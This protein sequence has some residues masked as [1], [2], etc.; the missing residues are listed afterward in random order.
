MSTVRIQVR[1]GT[2]SEWTSANPTLAAGEMG[3]ETDTR[4]IKVGTGS[5]AWTSLSYIASD[6]PGITE[7]AQ[8]AI[9]TALSMGSGLTKSYN[10]GTNTISLGIDSTVVALKSYVDDQITG[11]DNASA[12]DYV[13]LADVGNAGGPAKLDVDGNLLVPKSS[14]V[15][16]GAT[17]NDFETTLTVVDPTADRTITLPNAT[18]TVV[19]KDSTDTL[20]NKSISLTTNTITGTQAEFNSAM[21]DADFA[22]LA[23]SETLT[24]KTISLTSNTLSG[25]TAE[26]NTA[27]SDDNFV[28][29]T[30]T[31]T[32]TNK[33]LTSPTLTTPALGTPSSGTLTNATGLPVSGI[34]DS[35]SEALGL[36]SIE[37]GHASDTT[38]ARSGAGVV[39]IEG[40]EVTTNTA[41]QTL[42]NKTLTA[43]VISSITNGAATLTLPSTTGTVALTSDVTSAVNNLVDAAPGALDTLNELAAAIGDDANYAAG[44]TTALGGKLSL[45]GGTMTGA[46]T[47]SAAPASNLQ[48][49]TKLYVD[50]IAAAIAL[51][52]LNHLNDTTAVHGITNTADLAYVADIGTHNSD[53]TSV[54]GIPD[55]AALA[56]KTY[57]DGAVETHSNDTTNIHGISNF[58]NLMDK[59][60]DTMTGLLTLSGAPSSDLNA[61]TKK[62]VDDTVSGHAAVTTNVHGI[63]NTSL[64]ATTANVE[65]AKSEAIAAVTVTSLSLQNVNNTSDANK[66]VSTATQT[67]L[68]LKAPLA[69]PALT[70]T[71]TAPTA[72][73]ATDTTQ[74]ATT[75]FVRAEVAALVNSAG[76]TLD[77]LGEIATALGNDA[78]LSTTLTTSIGLK[79]PLASPTFTGTVTVAASG[80]AF[81]D[82]TQTKEGVPS[83]TP[84]IYK[85]A[86]YTLSAASERDSLIEVDSTSPVTI[87]IPTNS[88]VAYPVGTTLDILGTNT[89]LITIAGDSGVTVNATP[90]L[91]LRT[92]W[93]SC[94]L[95]KR[96]ENS[97]VAYGDLKA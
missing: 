26:F 47:L 41:T 14:I 35:T 43:P 77:T 29:L 94:T 22:S 88:A 46:I 71:P 58:A 40:V 34:V 83:R 65:T 8:D 3:V 80:V 82:G 81:T 85:T 16:E 39:T 73:A 55:T 60:G 36:G 4:K 9:D 61:A 20:T 86:S 75:A 64:L 49:A 21:S 38:I 33:T 19:L 90:G 78:N 12:A 52:G 69:S 37:L 1:R 32:L 27:L 28:T 18:G 87:T 13:L 30:G 15:L 66:P 48:P 42:T 70:G 92:Q 24:N 7:I 79:A 17:A 59:T 62:Y 6:A 31:E 93:S 96:A 89:G 45:S 10:D 76:S 97:W 74:I 50:D 72:A 44:V 95:F 63:A 84:I 67:A 91:K 68:D 56:T 11:L 25:T 54:H 53:T 51:D 2:A 23:G 5:T 57:A